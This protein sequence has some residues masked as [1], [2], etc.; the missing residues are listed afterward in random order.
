VGGRCVFVPG[1]A[2]FVSSLGM[3]FRGRGPLAQPRKAAEAIAE[4][5]GAEGPSDQPGARRGPERQ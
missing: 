1:S 3:L 5:M 4:A 2:M